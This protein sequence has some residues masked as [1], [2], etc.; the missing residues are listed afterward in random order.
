M[1]PPNVLCSGQHSKTSGVCIVKVLQYSVFNVFRDCDPFIDAQ[2][3]MHY[4]YVPPI[5]IYAGL[6]SFSCS[7]SLQMTQSRTSFEMASFP[8]K[9]VCQQFFAKD[10]VGWIGQSQ[11]L[12]GV[13]GTRR[14]RCLGIRQ[15]VCC[16]CDIGRWV[17]WKGDSGLRWCRFC[18]IVLGILE[19]VLMKW[20]FDWW[21]LNWVLAKREVFWVG[22][23]YNWNFVLFRL[24]WGT[25]GDCLSSCQIWAWF[26]LIFQIV[27]ILYCP[28]FAA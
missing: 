3:P 15:S 19:I 17:V 27:H 12:R 9:I 18:W 20:F 4:A 21:I 6:I 11:I 22:C 5:S 7:S 24:I 13:D 16:W 2:T 25:F 28:F 10:P 23:F 8:V 14:R 1:W 26:G